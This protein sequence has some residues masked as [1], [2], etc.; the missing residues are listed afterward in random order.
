MEGVRNRGKCIIVCVRLCCVVLC[1]V[2]LGEWNENDGPVWW[3]GPG[4]PI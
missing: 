4:E 2:C 3:A 1:C